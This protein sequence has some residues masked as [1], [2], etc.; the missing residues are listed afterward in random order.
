MLLV[1]VYAMP[2]VDFPSL[3]IGDNFFNLFVIGLASAIAAVGFGILTG[4]FTNSYQQAI[5][6]GSISVV[7]L[8]AIGGIWVPVF[9]MPNFMQIVSSYSP[10]N[11]GIEGFYNVLVRNLPIYDSLD[12]ILLLISFFIITMISS[13][14]IFRYKVN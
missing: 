11:W 6:F 14:V 10:L 1:G 12:E 4:T 13:I 8:A 7:I 5:T 9:A 3:Q 2:F